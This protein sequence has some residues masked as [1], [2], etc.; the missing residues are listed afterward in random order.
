MTQSGHYTLPLLTLSCFE[1]QT[2]RDEDFSCPRPQQNIDFRAE[3]NPQRIRPPEGIFQLARVLETMD[4]RIRILSSCLEH[5][6]SMSIKGSTSKECCYLQQVHPKRSEIFL[7]N[8]FGSYLV[9]F[10]WQTRYS[11]STTA[12]KNQTTCRTRSLHITSRSVWSRV[13]IGLDGSMFSE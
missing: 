3:N 13:D 6:E 8:S 12:G 1:K 11:A 9:E 2:S 5:C 4:L 7:I 10:R